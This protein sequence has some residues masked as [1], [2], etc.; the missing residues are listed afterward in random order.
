MPPREFSTAPGARAARANVLRPF[1]ARPWTLPDEKPTWGR[2]ATPSLPKEAE[3]EDEVVSIAAVDAET[4]TVSEPGPD[5]KCPFLWF[6]PGPK[7][8]LLTTVF[9][10]PVCSIS[11]P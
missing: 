6:A 11:T 5:W 1:I 9:R 2:F 3:T 7:L 4:S 8:A 10:K